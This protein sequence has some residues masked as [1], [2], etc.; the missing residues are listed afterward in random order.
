MD[1]REFLSAL[2]KSLSVLQE[3]ELRDIVSEYEQHIDIK[4]A[5]G[6]TEEEAIE[7][8]G[9]FSQLTAEL[10]EAYH[11]RADYAGGGK[12]RSRA[13]SPDKKKSGWD[14]GKTDV[15]T[16]A[17]GAGHRAAEGVLW[18]VRQTVRPFV[19]LW[20]KCRARVSS[21]KERGVAGQRENPVSEDEVRQ[22]DVRI[23]DCGDSHDRGAGAADS[24][25]G[26]G[27]R[28]G[29][30]S[31]GGE[32]GKR[33]RIR[34]R[35]WKG[36]M[37]IHGIGKGI[38]DIFRWIADMARLALVMIWNG[39][40]VM[41]SVTAGGFGLFCLYGL[42]VLAVLLVQGYPLA[43][44]TLGCLGLVMCSFSA[45]VIGFTFLRH[46]KGSGKDR[47]QRN[48]KI[49]R[50]KNGDGT[51]GDGMRD[52]VGSEDRNTGYGMRDRVGSEDRNAGYGMKDRE[53]PEDGDTGYGDDIEEDGSRPSAGEGGKDMIGEDEKNGGEILWANC[54]G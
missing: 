54:E 3:D 25:R 34:R 27:F 5:K 38:G 1:K 48:P 52:R 44:V 18:A 15:G 45:A 7:D 14:A 12:G 26:S 51:R 32:E 37:I 2:E 20:G 31:D 28:Q 47:R 17:K 21:M 40:W 42:G 30:R 49:R 33:G 16:M 39:C 29:L 9:S 13:A 4:V 35:K 11:V 10:L 43:G 22:G 50:D 53:A 46:F 23:E 41:F 6:L 19:W 36:E 24:A 8:F